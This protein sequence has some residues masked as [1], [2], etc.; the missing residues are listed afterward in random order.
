MSTY[1][2]C[3]KDANGHV[4]DLII[5]E[6][7]ALHILDICKITFEQRDQRYPPPW[8]PRNELKPPYIYK[9]HSKDD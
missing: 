6:S 1:N 4:Y 2:F 8:V 7:Q 5:T 9:I 3:I